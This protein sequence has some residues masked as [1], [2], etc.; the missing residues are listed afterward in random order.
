MESGLEILERCARNLPA[1]KLEFRKIET[2]LGMIYYAF[3]QDGEGR[4]HG[5]WGTEKIGRTIEFRNRDFVTA[6]VVAAALI[7][8]AQWFLSEAGKRGL[9]QN[10]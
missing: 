9:F 3:G 2:P 10:G 7:D 5:I 1:K 8:D 6:D 4:Y